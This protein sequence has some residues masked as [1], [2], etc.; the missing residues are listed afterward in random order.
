MIPDIR[1]QQYR[2]YLF[3][4]RYEGK[5]YRDFFPAALA[6]A[7]R[8]FAAAAIFARAAADMV[9]FPVDFFRLP[10]GLPRRA[11]NGLGTP[12]SASLRIF[13]NSLLRD[14]IWSLMSAALRSA[15]AVMFVIVFSSDESG[16]A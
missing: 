13:V 12:L 5:S 3:G 4:F 11:E 1:N 9:R 10:G 2:D 8:A 16:N 14:S 7:H 6:L 15:C